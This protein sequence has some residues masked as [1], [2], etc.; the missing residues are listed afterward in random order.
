MTKVYAKI[1]LKGKGSKY[2][3]F[4]EP[5]HKMY[6]SKDNIID[7]VV[8]FNPATSVEDGVWYYMIRVS[9]VTFAR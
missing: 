2:R 1:K 3:L 5:S 4:L 9:K 8:P 6:K 7:E